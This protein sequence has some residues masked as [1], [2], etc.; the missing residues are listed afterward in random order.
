[1]ASSC[2][3]EFRNIAMSYGGHRVLDGV[4]LRVHP[5]EC[6]ALTGANGCG[7]STLLRIAAGLI[8]PTSGTVA[9]ADGCPMQYIPDAFPPLVLTGRQ[10]LRA[11]VQVDCEADERLIRQF[12]MEAHLDSPI[13][14]YSKGMRGKIGALQALLARPKLLLMDE[15]VAGLDADSRDAFISAVKSHMEA[16]CAVLMACHEPELVSALATRVFHIEGGALV[17]GNWLAIRRDACLCP[18]CALFASG[19][20]PGRQV[21]PHA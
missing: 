4:S 19:E 12:H 20:C 15:P 8:R 5:G 9:M 17:P 21:C 2:A 1:M 7:K 10:F 18:G 16:G 11:M 14:G 13:S 3:L 6:V